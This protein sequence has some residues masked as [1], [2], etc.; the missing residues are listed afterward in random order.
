[1]ETNSI[2]LPSIND[3]DIKSSTILIVDDNPSNLG[4]IFNY[5]SKKGLKVLVADSGKSALKLLE[6]VSTPDL[7]LLDIIMPEIDGFEVSKRIK[8]I[9]RLKNI[10]IIFLSAL[11]TTAEKIKGFSAG[12]VDYVTKPF[13]Y[14]ELFARVITHLVIKKQR[15][16]LKK[17]NRKLEEVIER[18]DK[19]ISIISHDLRTPLSTIKGYSDII[20]EDFNELTGDEVLEYNGYINTVSTEINGLITNLLEWSRLM[21]NKE[22]Y[23]PSVINISEVLDKVISFS[24]QTADLKKIKLIGEFPEKL[25]CFADENML[26]TIFRNLVSNAIKYTF[27]N[28]TV[29]IYAS[30]VYEV[31]K[32]TIEDTGIGMKEDDIRKLFNIKEKFSNPGTKNERGT[33]LGLLITKEFIERNY[34]DIFV[35]S[36]LNK[37]SKF[38]ISIPK[39]DIR[40]L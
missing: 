17:I 7:I 29:K 15:E 14:A 40:D 27:E 8:S 23:S 4:L 16:E 11:T 2:E 20:Q 38:I 6:E 33:G 13:Q 30:E 25:N 10:P 21:S 19:L 12:G 5:F 3:I 34:G 37:G 32:V 35:E 24:K 1:M 28:G 39:N 18:K 22:F 9:E 31:V 36:E 26:F